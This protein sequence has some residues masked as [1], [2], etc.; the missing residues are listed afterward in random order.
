LLEEVVSKE[1]PTV[2]VD[3][4]SLPP[5]AP[6]RKR[7]TNQPLVEIEVRRSPRI[8]ELND[9]F[10]NHTN[11]NDKNCLT[12]NAAPPNLHNKLVKNLAVSFCKVGVEGI[13]KKLLKRGKMADKQGHWQASRERCQELIS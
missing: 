7:K 5:V 8:V 4:S 2:K 1:A 13:E 9:G 11:C 3:D 12:C 10:K 6:K